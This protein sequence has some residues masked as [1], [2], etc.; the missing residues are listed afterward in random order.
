MDISTFYKILQSPSHL[1][2][3]ERFELKE[4]IRKFPYFQTARIIY[5]LHLKQNKD[6]H[7]YETLKT[8][9]IYAGDRRHLKQILNRSLTA[10]LPEKKRA[11]KEEKKDVYMILED[12]QAKVERLLEENAKLKDDKQELHLVE[13]AQQ[14]EELLVNTETERTGFS[15][16]ELEDLPPIKEDVTED[17]RLIE[18]F[19]EHSPQP[20]KEN[21]FFDPI[22]MAQKSLEENDD[23]ISETLANLYYEQGYY[24][25][26]IKIYRK[27]ILLYPKNSSYFAAL[28]KKIEGKVN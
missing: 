2:D 27:L 7:Y 11:K 10:H 17:D 18:Q 8:T 9:S 14:I 23:I 6:I 25:K 20:K 19:L 16:E 22:K 13:Q 26:A 28:I 4:I 12:L 3:S 21:S 24:E 1:S 15:V 5:L